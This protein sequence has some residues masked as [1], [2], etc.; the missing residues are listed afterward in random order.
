MSQNLVRMIAPEAEEVIKDDQKASASYCEGEG[1]QK[2]KQNKLCS[3]VIVS[4]VV[5][6]IY[7]NN[8]IN[9][10]LTHPQNH[11]H[12]LYIVSLVFFLD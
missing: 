1:Q 6:H 8:Q 7:I 3:E 12:W 2:Q 9:E 11:W 5:L 10:P 4:C